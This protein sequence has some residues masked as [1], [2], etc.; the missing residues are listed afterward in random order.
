MKQVAEKLPRKLTDVRVKFTYP[1]MGGKKADAF[2][3]KYGL[4][5]LALKVDVQKVRRALYYLH[6][7]NYLYEN[8]EI[9]DELLR[10][11]EEDC[12]PI[13]DIEEAL[14]E[15]ALREQEE[16]TTRFSTCM[17]SNPITPDQIPK[18]LA[19]EYGNY[20]NIQRNGV[21]VHAHEQPNLL[22]MCFPTLFPEGTG[23]DYRNYEIPLT[24][25]EMVEHTLK[26][27]DPRFSQHYR[28]LFMMINVK[29]LEAA[30]KT[31]SPCMKGR[32]MKRT[33]DGSMVEVTPEVFNDFTKVVR[34]IAFRGV[35]DRTLKTVNSWKI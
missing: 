10:Q 19:D 2:R 34:F 24:T 15:Q 18:I 7:N 16:A 1:H 22:G 35:S 26:F 12:G 6:R 29:N 17:S 11:L 28:Y 4:R 31:I 20:V 14:V 9:S 21:A 33:V 30:Y 3:G 23:N 8:V 13:P 27:G 25:S 32:V 5:G